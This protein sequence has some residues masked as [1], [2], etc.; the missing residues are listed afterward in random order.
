MHGSPTINLACGWV[1]HPSYPERL[2]HVRPF[3]R[4][5]PTAIASHALLAYGRKASC[6][7]QA[8][9]LQLRSTPL[10]SR[11]REI[12]NRERCLAADASCRYQLHTPMRWRA[13]FQPTK[14]LTASPRWFLRTLS[15]GCALRATST[16]SY[17][18]PKTT[19]YA[20]LQA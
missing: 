4:T 13:S 16:G 18:L 2:V 1:R 15:P 7:F 9:P 8:G 11:V 3:A 10:Y 14:I 5:V 20:R 12:E 6:K 19:L 17:A